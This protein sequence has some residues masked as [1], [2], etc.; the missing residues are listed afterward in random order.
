[1]SSKNI[2]WHTNTQKEAVSS[3]NL[4]EVCVGVCVSLLKNRT[5]G[6]YS[7]CHCAECMCMYTSVKQQ[8]S[9]KSQ[10]PSGQSTP[11]LGF[12]PQCFPRP[13]SKIEVRCRGTVLISSAMT[14]HPTLHSPL[15][16]QHSQPFRP[17]SIALSSEPSQKKQTGR[18]KECASTHT[19]TGTASK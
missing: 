14:L 6:S 9:V 15:H 2:L 19:W 4:C 13:I 1:M 12:Q 5:K 8:S 17:Y 3:V 16:P 7:V 10:D 11:Y 18:Q